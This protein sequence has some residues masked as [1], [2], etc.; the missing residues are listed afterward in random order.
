MHFSTQFCFYYCF[1]D[2]T[3]SFEIYSPLC[4]FEEDVVCKI[5]NRPRHHDH[6]EQE[7]CTFTIPLILTYG[8][9]KQESKKSKNK[10]KRGR[11]LFVYHALI[12]SVK[13]IF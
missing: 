13:I 9:D 10:D 2:Y 5:N 12:F 8:D 6:E 1:Y 4:R 11:R 7:K 3:F